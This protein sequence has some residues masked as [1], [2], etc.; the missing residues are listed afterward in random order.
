MNAVV[1]TSDKD[2]RA[3][4]QEGASCL[5]CGRIPVCS[6]YMTIKQLIDSTWEEGK[7]PFEAERLAEICRYYQIYSIE[8]ESKVN[9][10]LVTK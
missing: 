10:E 9:D 6:V 4:F 2:K 1:Q 3:E 8:A 7:R 5:R